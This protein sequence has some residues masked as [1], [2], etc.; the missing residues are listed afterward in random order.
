MNESIRAPALSFWMII[1]MCSANAAEFNETDVIPAATSLLFTPTVIALT[2]EPYATG[3]S[4]DTARTLYFMADRSDYEFRQVPRDE[5]AKLTKTDH[6]QER[7]YTNRSA[8]RD[9]EVIYSQDCADLGFRFDT[10]PQDL[11]GR[12]TIQF[13]SVSFEVSMR[14]GSSIADAILHNDELWIGVYGAVLVASNAGAPLTRIN[15]GNLPVVNIVVDP[16]TSDVWVVTW[17]QLTQVSEGKEVKSRYWKYHEFDLSRNQPDIF[18]IAAEEEV[19]SNP[20]AVLARWLGPSSYEGLSQAHKTGVKL[21][22]E[23]FL[24]Y[25]AMSGMGYSHFPQLPIEL[26]V[27]LESAEPT[28]MWRKFACR[29]HG[30]LAKE[31]CSLELDEWPARLNPGRN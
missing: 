4:E 27:L 21:A 6:F 13:E 17:S 10:G 3:G 23:E 28:I 20:L 9:Y 14:C 22:G 7:T 31:L 2:L 15:V 19:N 26:A 5:F 29:S 16:W 12:R 18:V 11:T 24:Y 30:I 25:F 1:A 8:S